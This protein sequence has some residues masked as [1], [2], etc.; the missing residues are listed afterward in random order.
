[1][2]NLGILIAVANF[3]IGWGFITLQI[4]N[5]GSLKKWINQWFAVPYLVWVV[6]STLFIGLYCT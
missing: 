3:I 5:A 2:E 1:M 6:L 4:R